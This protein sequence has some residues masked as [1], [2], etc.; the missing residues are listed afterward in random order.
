MHGKKTRTAAL[1]IMAAALSAALVSCGGSGSANDGP[2][3]TVG[4]KN[5]T[6]PIIF[7]ELYSQAL[8]DEGFNVEKELDLGNVTTLDQALQSGEIDTYMEYTGTGLVTA[9]GYEGPQPESPEETYELAEERYEA[10]EPA[11]TLL[12]QASFNNNYAIAVRRD[13]AEEYDLQ[14]LGDLAEASPNLTFA[15]FSEFQQRE[16][17]FPNIQESYP[18]T[19]F[20]DVPI[21]NEIGLRYQALQQGEADTAVGFATDGQLLSDDLA[22]LEDEKEIWPYYHPAPVID[23]RYLDEHPRAADV[24]NEVTAALD[25]ET[26]RELNGRVDLDRE[27]PEDV[28]ADFLEEEGIVE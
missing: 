7:G 19:D 27:D 2:T 9:L 3:I 23:Q 24:M 26:Q 1:T 4:S 10:R 20:E 15:S 6:E 21:V 11:A 28:A 5:F 8:E 16:D 18:A 25:L 13:V 12:E 17:G 14:T 22:V